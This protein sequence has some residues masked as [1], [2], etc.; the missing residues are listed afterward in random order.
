MT[1][2]A[3][4]TTCG[5][6]LAIAAG[7]VA[8]RTG[9][10]LA[11]ALGVASPSA[12]EATRVALGWWLISGAGFIGSFLAA[13]LLSD[14]TERPFL[15][16]LLWLL[17]AAFFLVLAGAEHIAPVAAPSSFTIALAAN[18]AAFGL[19]LSTAVCGSYFAMER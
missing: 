13:R 6:L 17:A 7:L 2:F 1:T 12:A 5:V 9:F 4:A 11:G 14:P 10:W 15:R 19:G 16:K 8:E 18:L 3:T